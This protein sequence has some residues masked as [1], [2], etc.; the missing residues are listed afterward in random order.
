VR[1]VRLLAKTG[2]FA[3][4]LGYGRRLRDRGF[5]T[6][7]LAQQLGDVLAGEH[8]DDE[9]MR[10]YSELVEF[11]PA[12][13]ASRKLLGDIYLRH[14][15]YAEAY[16]QYKGLTALDPKEPTHFIRLASAAAGAGRVDEAL[17]IEREVTAD[18]GRPGSDDPR[19]WARLWSAARLG[20]LLD[21]K[22]GGGLKAAATN[23]E[24]EKSFDE[25]I[26]R[27]L[28]DLQLFAGPGTLALL[29]W[30]DLD[31]RLT[32]ASADEKKETL[33][34]EATDAGVVGLTALMISPETWTKNQWAARFK[35]DPPERAVKFTLITLTWDDKSFAVKT[36]PGELSPGSR[37]A[38]L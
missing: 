29:T 32:L 11:D 23:P 21:G 15:W 2:N 26:G 28:K 5:L 10:T 37:Q 3:E 8:L 14:G 33:A 27:K 25:S 24:A 12:S 17:R 30:E 36:A 16:R 20:L 18:A 19:Y 38:S 9:A 34:G 13:I 7:T 31:A 22:A 35:A 4:A 6:P 1:L